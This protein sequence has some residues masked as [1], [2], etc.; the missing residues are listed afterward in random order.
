MLSL[1]LLM[2]TFFLFSPPR[3]RTYPGAI[4]WS[5]LSLLKPLTDLMSLNGIVSTVRGV[6]IK[7]F[8]LYLAAA[9]GLLLVAWRAA[10][11]Q[12]T[13]WIE[14]ARQSPWFYGQ[15][16]L[17]G[18]VALSALSGV[19]AGAPTYALSQAGIYALVLAWALAVGWTLD[20]RDLPKLLAGLT[21]ITAGGAALCVWY[22]YER[23]PFHRPGFPLGNPNVLAACL[24]PAI[25]VAVAALA[26]AVRRF[27]NEN[28]TTGLRR[29]ALGLAA[30]IPL[31]W[32]FALARGRGASLALL[33]GVGTALFFAGGK[34]LRWILVM[35]LVL[36]SLAA[37]SWY[38]RIGGREGLAGLGGAT[39]RFRLYAWRYAA[40]LW[41]ERPIA[42]HGA[43]AYPRL[44]GQLA[45]RDR[46]LDPA[47]FMGELLEHAH[48]ELFEV[49]T[50]IGLVG[51]ITF[52]GGFLATFVAAAALLRETRRAPDYWLLVALVASLMA[53]TADAMFGV[54]PRLPGTPAIFYTLLGATWAMARCHEAEGRTG[55]GISATLAALVPR[56]PAR[57]AVRYAVATGWALAAAGCAT[58]AL[59]NWQGALTEARA[60]NAYVDGNAG[61]ARHAA[62]HASTRLLDPVRRLLAKELVVRAQLGL[63]YE[64]RDAFERTIQR[65]GIPLDQLSETVQTDPELHETWLHA[66]EM[67]GAAYEAA[68]RLASVVPMSLD[69][70][71]IAA[72]GS[73]VM[74]SLLIR[75][76]PVAA[77]DWAR[78]AVRLWRLQR[79][80][81]PY[82]LETL[83]SLIRYRGTVPYELGVLRDALRSTEASGQW[84]ERLRELGRRNGFEETLR[85]FLSVA[86]PLDAETDLDTLIAS[87]APETYRLTAAWAALEHQFVAARTYALQA[88]ELY[89]PMRPR[90]PTL[91]SMA[92][93]ELAEYTLLESPANAEET[94]RLVRDAISA[95]PVIQQQK[96]EAMVAP[97]RRL[98]LEALLVSGREAEAR[99][100][101]RAADPS[102]EAPTAQLASLYVGLAQRFLRPDVRH[103]DW[104]EKWLSAAIR[105]Q[106]KNLRAWGWRTWLAARN[107]DVERVQSLLLRAVAAGVTPENVRRIRSSL[108]QEYP[109]LCDDLGE[110]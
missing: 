65:R 13:E 71:K 81:T 91:Y 50:E 68:D 107:G 26:E 75:T 18:W 25:M 90:F 40:E 56:A 96:Y 17:A 72:R 60:H 35:L 74:A 42:G 48:N 104:V 45:V 2:A 58:L 88:A 99:R 66:V 85:Q 28:I 84:V 53:L 92:L 82:D 73:E 98:L 78:R 33:A 109:D 76:D 6:E 7:D 44:A 30:L 105:H 36:L 46:A 55:N 32:C 1:L 51:G 95:L 52:V 31:T 21:A 14:K 108:C 86:G 77:K 110:P 62:H 103:R 63:A 106:P 16:L 64:A 94:I 37:G 101:M 22:Y 87:M 9:A 80:W 34:R 23:N 39:I 29:A 49:L 19:W 3:G 97:Y 79:V 10:Q 24:L 43:G 67:C 11:L 57:P 27:R 59:T 5:D 93:S 83:M 4:P 12:G 38:S 61:L 70:A 15:L 89:Q 54:G 20:R 41:Q 8:A 102:I 100:V 47:A 69:T